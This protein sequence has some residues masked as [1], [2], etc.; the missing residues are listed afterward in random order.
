MRAT[1]TS[2]QPWTTTQPTR[3]FVT[4][5]VTSLGP[6]RSLVGSVI[7]TS[8]LLT[9]EAPGIEPTRSTYTFETER[10]RVGG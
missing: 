4:V 3:S 7:Y 6:I 9:Y 2:G 1:R 5:A 10:D 8:S